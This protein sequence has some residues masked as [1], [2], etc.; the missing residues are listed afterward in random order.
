M[1]RVTPDP[2]QTPSLADALPGGVI[3]R[4]QGDNAHGTLGVGRLTI[5][6]TFLN[7]C[8]SETFVTATVEGHGRR[9]VF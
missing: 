6:T 4:D 3:V 9:N 7:H 8:C 5:H 2:E 1:N